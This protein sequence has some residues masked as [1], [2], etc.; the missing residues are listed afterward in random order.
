MSATSFVGGCSA[1]IHLE[2]EAMSDDLDRKF[3]EAM[4]QIGLAPVDVSG[5]KRADDHSS[6]FPLGAYSRSQ[7]QKASLSFDIVEEI[8]AMPIDWIWPGRLARGKLTL[9]SGDPGL[10]KSQLTT[11]IAARISTNANWPDGGEAP[12]GSIIILS[13]EDSVADTLRPRLELAGADLKR[14]HALKAAFG[15][16]GQR[17]TFS[18]QGDLAALGDKVKSLGDCALIVIDPVTSYMEKSTCTARLTCG[19]YWNRWPTLP[20]RTMLPC[21]SFRIHLKH[22]R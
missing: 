17:H 10:G 2:N 5:L 16:D 12:S 15:P 6:P 4:A 8:S 14:I 18:L 20:T 11:D 19:Q 21:W 7:N 1:V 9:I 13:A 3:D 22:R